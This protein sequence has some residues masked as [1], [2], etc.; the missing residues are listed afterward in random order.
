MKS[1]IKFR[2]IHP[3]DFD[4]IKKLHEELFPVR[5]SDSFYTDA[6]QKRGIN[7]GQLFT[8]IAVDSDNIIIGFIFAQFIDTKECEHSDIFRRNSKATELCYILTLGLKTTHRRSKLGSKLV[9][10][11][12]DYAKGNLA[13]G[14][15]YLHVIHYNVAVS[16]ISVAL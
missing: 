5:Y 12:V 16:I 7:G 14:A 6:C 4:Q 13:C 2:E 11:C 10:H 8:S 9:T 3:D 15:L 1:H